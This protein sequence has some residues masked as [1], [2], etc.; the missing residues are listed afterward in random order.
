LRD[1]L[2]DVKKLREIRLW[3]TKMFIEESEFSVSVNEKD[4][5]SF[6]TGV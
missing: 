6:T 5:I 1:A 4:K 3:L 2:W